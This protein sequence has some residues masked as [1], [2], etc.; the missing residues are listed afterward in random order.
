MS[1]KTRVLCSARVF[2]AAFA[3]AGLF[4]F[5]CNRQPARPQTERIAILRFE[6]LGPDT[7]TDWM[8]RAFSEILTTELSGAPG[9]YAIP[10]SRMHS[11]QQAL[12]VRPITA[13]GISAERTLALA[14]GANRIGYGE[15]WVREG[16]LEARLSIEDPQTGA[17]FQVVS[18]TAGSN[19]AITA[20][21]GLAR[22]IAE[23]PAPYGTRNPQALQAWVAALESTGAAAATGNLERAIA[24]DP[25]FGPAYRMLAER[26]T[27]G[28]DRDGALAVLETALA[29][30]GRISEAERAHLQLDI[31]T[32]NS[33]EAGRQRA[34]DALVKLNAHDAMAWRGLAEAAMARREYPTAVAAYQ[35]SLEVEP[36]DADG[37]NRLGYAAS[38]AG[39]LN[40]AVTALRR[41]QA[42]R[43]AD[44]NPLDS[45]GDAYLLADRFREADD[46]YLQAARKDPAYPRTAELF[47]AA[48]ARLMS[49]D[50]A[51]ADALSKQYAE[52]REAA[53]DPLVEAFRAEWSWMS[54]RR[55]AGYDRLA[56]FARVLEKG[57]LREAASRSYGELAVWSLMLG[58]RAAAD[59]MARKAVKLAGP[60]SAA[61]AA[62]AR[63]LVQEP[64]SAAEWA[65]RAERLF[66]DAPKSSLRDLALGYALLVSKEFQPASVVLKQIYER[67]GA[68]ADEIGY[69]LAWSLLETDR[70]KEA[71]PLL[72]WNPIPP[73]TGPGTLLSF[74]FP[75]YYYLRGL[76][77]EKEGKADE[78]RTNY[79]LFLE[80]SGPDAMM[81]GEEKKVRA[82]L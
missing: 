9:I 12:G 68:A 25:D 60:G 53:Q 67:G 20:A 43:P 27:Q 82:G 1:C 80:L 39:D 19:D 4:A 40:G 16:R 22:Q 2:Q 75:R 51:G 34:L 26:K 62:V 69:L 72:R 48:M 55:H 37:W 3:I 7:A 35:K 45:L 71:A 47:K 38:Y 74:Y 59:E 29:R 50:V 56:A 6:N 18:A 13:P 11:F 33:D 21:S 36:E 31:A 49:G 52:A 44:A 46:C 65:E 5:A 57:E 63:F 81:W 10:A 15:Y 78:A 70:A 23:R 14:A 28:Q 24:A 61:T 58:E 64:G 54:G 30:G 17:V 79:R 32:L 73:L 42:L 41:Y 77:A 8:G 66:P 76:E